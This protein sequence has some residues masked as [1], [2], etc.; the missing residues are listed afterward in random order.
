MHDPE[1]DSLLPLPTATFHI[2]LALAGDD[3]HGYAI[4]QEVAARTNDTVRLSAGTLYRSIQRMLEQGLIE[5]L[6]ERPV[7]ELDDERRRYYR[8]TA[9]G[10][11]VASAEARRLAALVKLARA[12]GFVPEKV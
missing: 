8:L 9:F 12:S 10:R 6:R 2:L 4:M 3:L 7:P 1:I 5:E 11:N